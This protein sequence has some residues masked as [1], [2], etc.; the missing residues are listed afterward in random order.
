M[1]RKQE[2]KLL[3]ARERAA[4]L[5]LSSCFRWRQNYQSFLFLSLSQG[6][7]CVLVGWCDCKQSRLLVP[8][9]GARV[10][11]RVREERGIGGT[12]GRKPETPKRPLSPLSFFLFSLARASFPDVSLSF[13]MMMMAT[14]GTA[15]DYALARAS[16]TSLDTMFRG[17]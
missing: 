6:P 9:R 17:F 14:S 10:S 11:E 1:P 16:G 2:K 4:G 8:G 3:K 7:L 15:K 12:Q 5:L 13:L